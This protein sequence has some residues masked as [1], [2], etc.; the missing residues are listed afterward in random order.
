MVVL[1]DFQAALK[2][3][4]GVFRFPERKDICTKMISKRN[5]LHGLY[6]L[7]KGNFI[8]GLMAA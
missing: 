1:Y 6:Y 2:F 3:Q 7:S 5:D 4:P 8:E